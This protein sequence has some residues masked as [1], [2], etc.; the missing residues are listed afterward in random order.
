MFAY[1]SGIF[2]RT[3]AVKLPA[4]KEEDEERVRSVLA[5]SKNDISHYTYIHPL[6]AYYSKFLTDNSNDFANTICRGV[7]SPTYIAD[8]QAI[9]PILTIVRSLDADDKIIFDAFAQSLVTKSKGS[10]D[11]HI[12]TICTRVG[13]SLGRILMDNIEVYVKKYIEINSISLDSVP[14]AIGFYE[15]LGF[16]NEPE[17]DLSSDVSPM[18]KMLGGLSKRKRTQR[19]RLSRKANA[20]IYGLKNNVKHIVFYV[21]KR[22]GLF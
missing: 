1:L 14:E 3:P 22:R 16:K 7:V 17:E 11:L 4:T 9:E 2:R 18:K 10:A 21:P 5:T 15:K 8:V 13:S 20:R 19:K 6:Y 12:F